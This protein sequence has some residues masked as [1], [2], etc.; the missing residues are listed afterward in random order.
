MRRDPLRSFLPATLFFGCI[1]FVAILWNLLGFV[2][3][4]LRGDEGTIDDV[5]GLLR[6]CAWLLICALTAGGSVSSSRRLLHNQTTKLKNLVTGGLVGTCYTLSC[7]LLFGY[8]MPVAP[9]IGLGLCTQLGIWY[10]VTSGLN[11]AF[12]SLDA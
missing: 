2:Y 12:Q 10:A 4:R 11:A 9:M 7:V 5:T 8:G 3:S 1:F 6:L